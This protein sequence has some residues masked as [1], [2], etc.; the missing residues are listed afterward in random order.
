ML[1]FG[2]CNLVRWHVLES[3]LQ[4]GTYIA[5]VKLCIFVSVAHA[6]AMSNIMILLKQDGYE[7]YRFS[8]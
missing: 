5:S 6:E 7:F 8:A 2:R 4:F 3:R 1:T